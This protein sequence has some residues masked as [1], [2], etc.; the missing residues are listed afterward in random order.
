MLS[1]YVSEDQNKERIG[2]IGVRIG[3]ER[4]E[5]LENVWKK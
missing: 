3:R 5:Q 1:N 4:I 2:Q